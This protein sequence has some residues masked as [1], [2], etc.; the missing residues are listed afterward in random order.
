MNNYKCAYDLLTSSIIHS[1]VPYLVKKST[2]FNLFELNS[3]LMSK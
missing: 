2:I 3:N 1:V